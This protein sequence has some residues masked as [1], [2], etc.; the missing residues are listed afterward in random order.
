MLVERG[1][2]RVGAVL[3]VALLMSG[4][5]WA[6]GTSGADAAKARNEHMKALGASVKPLVDQLKTDTPDI[7]VVKAST[8]KIAIAGTQLPAWFP[9]GSGPESGAKT[10]ALPEIWTDAA[11]FAAAEKT[12]TAESAKLDGLAKAGDLNGVKA[13]F[14]LVGAACQGCHKKYRDP[15]KS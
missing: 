2:H 8:A 14:A 4:A 3:M 6:A 10:R 11:G 1:F 5:A 13:Q 12:F 7:A 9:K 15:E